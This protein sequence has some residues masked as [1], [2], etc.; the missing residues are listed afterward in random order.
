MTNTK[1]TISRRAVLKSGAAA[2]TL[3]MLP[4]WAGS[5]QAA[6]S[7][8]RAGITGYNV[9]NTLD[10]AQTTLI[11]EAYVVWGL[12]NCLLKF[13][14][15]MNIVPDLAESYESVSPTLLR[16]KLRQGVKFHDGVE[17]TS[18]DVKFTL[19]RLRDDATGSPH[20]SKFK[21]ISEIRTPDDYT[22]E[23]ETAEP[24]APMLSYL[25]NTRTGS[26][27]VPMHL[28]KDGTPDDFATNPVGTGPFKMK[29]YEPGARIDLLAH[30]EYF[31]DGLPKVEAVEIPL[32]AEETAGVTALLGGSID[33]TSTAP[34]ADIPD[35]EQDDRAQVLKTPGTSTRFVSLNNKVAPFDDVHFRRACSF[36]FDRQAMVDVV[37]FGEGRV[38]NG[39]IPSSISWAATQERPPEI[40]L[41]PEKALEELE[42]SKYGKGAEATVLTWGSGWWKRFAEVFVLQVNDV[43]GVNFKVEVSDS[44]TVYQRMQTGDVQASIWGWLGLVDPDEYAYEVYHTNGSRNYE[45]YSNPEVD[46]LLEEARRTMDQG[47]RGDL[48]RQAE[49]LAIED[50]PVLPCF[51]SNVHNLLAPKVSGFVQRPY[52]GFGAQLAEVSD[53]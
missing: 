18:A 7:T 17:M 45:N 48:Y 13:D 15:N 14:E 35:L 40:G 36:A 31:E 37:L 30:D 4:L 51:E 26:Q 49:A 2:G 16:F 47:P 20:Q 27:I 24:F 34:F 43:L 38:S 33:I 1:T 25:T 9:I 21:P 50:C 46:K 29:S 22:V 19:D 42:K 3:A 44:G 32:I 11:P 23:I 28:L 10:P 12:F 5:A 8:L 53:C 6:C 41:N 52:S 39:I